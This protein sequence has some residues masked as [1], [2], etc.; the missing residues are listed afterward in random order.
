M[1]CEGIC[2]NTVG[3][4]HCDCMSG[5]ELTS[6]RFSC[7]GTVQP[8]LSV[9]SYIC[10]VVNAAS[11]FLLFFKTKCSTVPSCF[12]TLLHSPFL[13]FLSPLP[14]SPLHFIFL[15]FAFYFQ[16]EIADIDECAGPNEC[17]QEC[18]NT[19][20]SF[21]CTCLPGFVL[22]SD[23]INCERKNNHHRHASPENGCV[24]PFTS[25]TFSLFSNRQLHCR[26]RM[27]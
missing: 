24:C 26:P 1:Q 9:H 18:S 19:V 22:N 7:S 17:H 10:M 4:F 15:I 25:V 6:D 13:P 23:G 5:F 3:S 2:V 12:S 21:V 20:G 8:S 27:L 14:S 11:P 16:L